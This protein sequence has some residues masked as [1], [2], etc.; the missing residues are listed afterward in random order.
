MKKLS[1]GIDVGSTTVKMVVL[2]EKKQTLFAKYE[3]HYSDIKTATKKFYWKL[4]KS[5]VINRSH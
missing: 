4:R 2:N 1:A 5:S 3:R